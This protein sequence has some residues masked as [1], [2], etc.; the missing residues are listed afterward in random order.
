M[1]TRNWLTRNK[2]KAIPLET[3]FLVGLLIVISGCC[4][5]EVFLPAGNFT[6]SRDNH[7]YKYLTIGTQ[8][9]MAENLAYL[10]DSTPELAGTGITSMAVGRYGVLRIRLVPVSKVLSQTFSAISGHV[11]EKT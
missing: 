5:P 7:V 6:D 1:Q 10:P 3:A 11:T 2:L 8:V 9:W 4:K